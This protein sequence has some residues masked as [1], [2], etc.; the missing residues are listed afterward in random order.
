MPKSNVVRVRSL[1]IL[2]QR[3]KSPLNFCPVLLNME[4]F[5]AYVYMILYA[6][7]VLA[8]AGV[9]FAVGK[10]IQ[11]STALS[12]SPLV[13]RRHS[14]KLL[15]KVLIKLPSKNKVIF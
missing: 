8:G 12:G 11:L 2:E 9:L 5:G 15:K 6:S 14:G 10:V 7:L 3:F 13:P 4:M 1:L